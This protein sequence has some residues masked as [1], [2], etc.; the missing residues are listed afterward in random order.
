MEHDHM[1][2]WLMVFTYSWL[3]VEDRRKRCVYSQF[4]S[5]RKDNTLL[6]L[7]RMRVGILGSLCRSF[8]SFSSFASHIRRV[9]LFSGELHESFNIEQRYTLV[10][11]VNKPITPVCST[12]APQLYQYIRWKLKCNLFDEQFRST[13]HF[14]VVISM[15][16]SN[17]L[18]C[19]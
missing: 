13:S 2:M 5:G 7:C 11:H 4:S 17:C 3:E 6:F 14:S 18:F 12:S 16:W 9:L 15:D 8:F 19:F 10:T 1:W